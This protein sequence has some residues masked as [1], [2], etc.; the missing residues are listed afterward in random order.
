MTDVIQTIQIGHDLHIVSTWQI[1]AGIN[2]EHKIQ[3]KQKSNQQK[4]DEYCMSP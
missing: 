4:F 3:T 1:S 2:H